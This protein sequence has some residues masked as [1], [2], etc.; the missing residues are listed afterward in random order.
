[1]HYISQT[2]GKAFSIEAG[3]EIGCFEKS[4]TTTTSLRRSAGELE[5]RDRT[6]FH[7]VVRMEIAVKN[8]IKRIVI[9]PFHVDWR[10]GFHFSKQLQPLLDTQLMNTLQIVVSV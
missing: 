9:L 8:S 7:I 5:S 2:C 1:M 4:S 10:S 3:I 6:C